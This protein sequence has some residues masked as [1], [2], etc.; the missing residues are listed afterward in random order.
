MKA[1][2]PKIQSLHDTY[3]SKAVRGQQN[4][5]VE[6]ARSIGRPAPLDALIAVLLP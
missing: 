3:W 4:W 5:R 2:E 6:L 1:L